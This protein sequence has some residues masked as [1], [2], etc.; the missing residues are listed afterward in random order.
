MPWPHVSSRIV[1]ASGEVEELDMD[2]IVRDGHMT[3]LT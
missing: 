1:Y 3:L 2:E